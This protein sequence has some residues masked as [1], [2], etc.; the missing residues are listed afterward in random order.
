MEN[1]ENPFNIDPKQQKKYEARKRAE[2]IKE[3]EA[4]YQDDLSSYTETE[5]EM[6][7]VESE[8]ENIAIQEVIE[9]IKRKDPEIY[10]GEKNLFEELKQSHKGAESGAQTKA[11][12]E[13]SYRLKDYYREQTL[14][15]MQKEKEGSDEEQQSNPE[16]ATDSEGHQEESTEKDRRHER[17]KRKAE[18]SEEQK[19]NIKDFISAL[20]KVDTTDDLFQKKKEEEV[21]E[22]N[23]DEF[24]TDYILKGGW[25]KEEEAKDDGDIKFLEEDSEE[26]ELI[27]EFDKETMPTAQGKFA[28]VKK[29]SQKRKRKELKKK[30]RNREEEKTKQ[31]EIKRLKNLKKQQ[32]A[33]RLAILRSVSG[34]SKRQASK[35]KLEEVYN[36]KEF[37]K[38]MESLFGEEYFKKKEEERPKIKGYEA[39]AQELKQLED[40]AE[41][42]EMQQDRTSMSEIKKILS[43]IKEIGK[44]YASLKKQGDFEYVEMPTVNIGLT[45]RE[46]LLADDKFLKRNYSIKNYAP[47]KDKYERR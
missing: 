26:I 14:D 25:Q 11:S 2:E 41:K 1:N 38:T 42:A 12:R 21:E 31:E 35:I 34:L 15:K 47:F 33:D 45:T 10:D 13:A 5:E 24:L 18:Y 39:E 36:K 16:E 8:E 32:F 4:K 7:Y 22:E 44:E 29:A 37:D 3:L 40:L 30:L 43:E 19:K 9:K 6:E 28:T 27:E 46:I 20:N 23:Q 17:I